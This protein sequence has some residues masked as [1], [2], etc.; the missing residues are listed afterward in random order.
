MITNDANN[1]N[2]VTI[3]VHSH[4]AKNPKPSAAPIPAIAGKQAAQEKAE[5]TVPITP[6]L[7]EIRD[8]KL[9]LLILFINL[10]I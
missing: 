9:N 3:M 1:G 4:C 2:Q 7:S 10:I 8:I 5:R 6:A